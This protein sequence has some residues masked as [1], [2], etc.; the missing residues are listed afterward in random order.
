[1]VDFTFTFMTHGVPE[2]IDD[3]LKLTTAVPAVAVT[4]PPV[5]PVA[6]SPFGV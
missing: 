3:A 6:L 4:V 1:M 2:A 5:Q